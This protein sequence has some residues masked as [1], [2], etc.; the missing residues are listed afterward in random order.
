MRPV[1]E[2]AADL[3][4]DWQNDAGTGIGAFGVYNPD[5]VDEVS[6]TVDWESMTNAQLL[7]FIDNNVLD[8][9]AIRRSNG[10]WTGVVDFNPRKGE[11]N[12]FETTMMDD[13]ALAIWVAKRLFTHIDSDR[14]VW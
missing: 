13:R 7:K 14:L 2:I 3:V 9:T 4:K 8:Y 1:S 6:K 12:Q 11:Y 10:S 5:M